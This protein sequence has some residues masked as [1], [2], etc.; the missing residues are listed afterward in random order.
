MKDVRLL[1]LNLK[2]FKGVREFSLK[3]EGQNVKVFGDNATGKTTLFDGFVWLLFDKDSQNKKDFSIKTL[4]K[5][6][7]GL[8]GLEHEVEGVF[9]IDGKQ[10][11]LRKVFSEKWTK[12]RGSAEK[13]FSGHTTDYYIDGVPSKKKDYDQAISDIVA[14]D[15]FKL[16][17]SPAY[18]NEQLHWQDRRKILLQVCGDIRDE[19]VIASNN[20]LSKLPAILN[21]RTIENHRK[22]I[23]ARRAEINKELDKIPVR[24]DEVQR[25]IPDIS[26]LNEDEIQ[27]KYL[28]FGVEIENKQAELT[29]VKSG[30]E[31]VEKQKQLREIEIELID[32]KNKHQSLNQDKVSAK[33]QEFYKLQQEVGDVEFRITQLQRQ[34]KLNADTITRKK[35][36]ADRLRNEWFEVNQ[37]EFKHETDCV[38]PTCGQDLPENQVQE[39]KDKALAAFNK[40]K[41]ERLE[42]VTNRGKSAKSETDQ[43]EKENESITTEIEIL[44]TQVVQKQELVNG[45]KLEIDELQNSV[46]N[47]EEDPEYQSRQKQI[48]S[49]KE[50]INKLQTSVQESVDKVQREIFDLKSQATALE[51]D[52]AKF[53][54]VRQY[55]T[56]ISELE[57]QERTLAAEFE[58]LEQELYLTEEFIRTK[59]EKLE[60]KINSKFRHANFKLFEQQINGGL[61]EVCET[62]FDGV[63]YGSGLNNAAKINVGLDIIDTLSEH[64]GLLAPIFVDNSEAVTKII[65]T[66][67]QMISLVV[68]EPDKELRV[69]I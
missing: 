57:D 14:E 38:C 59:V 7:Q 18:F 30:S 21:G 17:T 45:L 41:S 42:S 19:E 8:H 26:H 51:S 62:T 46:P 35:T 23:A 36:E 32:L 37:E 69:A 67:A 44:K 22:V 31:V 2:N 27:T 66:K 28:E 24:I 6:G 53:N 1:E 10:L 56:R 47:I 13:Q 50:D 9:L 25:S 60:Q 20:A 40:S 34:I 48:H 15:I 54:Q 4:N 64:Y 29:R 5:G 3:S 65:D 63:P 39:T 58:K 68:S 55:E 43:L 52:K 33:R 61:T 12:K 11:S 49:I 16:L